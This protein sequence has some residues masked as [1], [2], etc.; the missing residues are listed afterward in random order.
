MGDERMY[1]IL[2]LL[3]EIS[4]MINEL[5]RIKY[6]KKLYE[7][8]GNWCDVQVDDNKWIKWK[9]DKVIHNPTIYVRID[10]SVLPL[11]TACSRLSS[12]PFSVNINGLSLLMLLSKYGINEVI[13]FLTQVR[14]YLQEHLER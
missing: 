3:K 4:F 8:A 5:N 2:E 10:E 6:R 13:V 11:V 14:E 1:T 9:I 12:N 7:I